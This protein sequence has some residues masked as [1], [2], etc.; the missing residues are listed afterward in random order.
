[1]KCEYEYL[2]FVLV[3]SSPKTDV[4]LCKNKRS[5]NELGTVRWHGAWRKYCYFVTY[6]SVYDDKCLD[7]IKDFLKQVQSQYKSK[8]NGMLK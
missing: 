5:G 2:I 7:D 4:W 6:D 3:R 1:M 8:K